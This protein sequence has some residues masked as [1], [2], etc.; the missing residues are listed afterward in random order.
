MKDLA[1]RGPD[2]PGGRL[3]RAAAMAMGASVLA[4][5]LI[6]L[7]SVASTFILARLLVP[8]DF[9]IA[10]LGLLIVY[11]L[12][13]LTDIGI[14]QAL[15]R[16]SSTDLVHRARTAFWLVTAL[17]WVMY[18]LTF[19][20]AGSIAS[21]YQQ[22]EVAPML[23]V[24]VLAVPIYAVSRIP[25]A[26][27]ERQMSFGRKMLPEVLGSLV[28]AVVAV[29][30]AYLHFGFWSLVV[31]TVL[32]SVVIS[33]GTFVI[34]E[35]RPALTFDRTVA[36][37]LITY[38]RY[39]MAGSIFR[40]AYTNVDNALVGKV[41]GVA[42]LGFYSMA[43]TLAN[44]VAVQISDPMG[45]VLFPTYSKLLPD[46]AQAARAAAFA[47]RYV[48]LVISPVTVLGIVAMPVLL[49]AVLGDKWL[50]ALVPIQMLMGYGWART[51]APVQW[52]LML[53]ADLNAT[54]MRINLA[55]LAVALVLAYPAAARFGIVGVAATFTVLELVRLAW[56]GQT[57]ARYLG[58][59]LRHQF[60][61]TLPG[62][63]ASSLAG[64][65][66]WLLIR[67]LRPL[68]IVAVLGCVTASG[69]LYLA[70]LVLLGDLRPDRVRSAMKIV[71]GGRM[72]V[73]PIQRS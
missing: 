41:L 69:L 21:F 22:P 56:M 62:L 6:R 17:G 48:S 57:T 52:A 31:G 4:T 59:G 15:V 35:W 72:A 33:A 60:A 61:A 70:T 53:A 66:L 29:A 11:F 47:L 13:P 9:G 32:R 18:G 64:A 26:L 58:F 25:S 50:P 55:S 23:R 38:A 63:A 14:A 54:S 19:I 10:S 34:A 71:L 30:L 39:L 24:M 44:L 1:D 68:Q 16:A 3:A 46:R 28:N 12:T 73:A 65:V 36:Q 42:A 5:S 67:D 20:G 27:L 7:V 45:R 37:E 43:Y 51:L 49:P 2:R 40:L 8:T